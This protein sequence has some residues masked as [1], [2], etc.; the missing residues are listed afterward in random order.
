MIRV[1]ILPILHIIDERGDQRGPKYVKWRDDLTGIEPPRWGIMDY[2][3]ID[4]C[5]MTATVT[6][7]EHEQLVAESD[8]RSAPEDIDQPISAIALSQVVTVMEALRIP[9][10]WVTTSHT[11]R[12]ILRMIAGLF[13]FAQRHHGMHLEELIDN[14]AQLDVK[15]NQIP[16]IRS[17]RILI[18][19]QN[20]GYDYSAV[21]PSW[22]VRQI[23]KHLSDQWGASSF[24]IGGV[25]F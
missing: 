15:W 5:L 25:E 14:Q 11:Y 1:Y 16:A 2:G 18:T 22:T 13:L 24:V 17:T 20:L 19:A 21:L 10:G 12:E 23:L 3:L 7:A 9:A 6:Q 8:V 4:A